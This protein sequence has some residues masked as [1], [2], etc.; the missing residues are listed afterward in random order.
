M[1]SFSDLYYKLR[2]NISSQNKI[3]TLGGKRAFWAIFIFSLSLVCRAGEWAIEA[4]NRQAS[5]KGT[6]TLFLQSSSPCTPL[7][8]RVD[9]IS[10]KHGTNVGHLLLLLLSLAF[11]NLFTSLKVTFHF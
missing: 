11:C 7:D 10:G 8:A 3:K 5:S 9:A 6:F 4:H 1:C 2:L